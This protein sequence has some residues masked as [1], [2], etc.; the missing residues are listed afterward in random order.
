MINVVQWCANTNTNTNTKYNYTTHNNPMMIMICA[1][2][3]N[4]IISL[5]AIQLYRSIPSNDD[6]YICMFVQNAGTDLN[7][8]AMQCNAHCTSHNNVIKQFWIYAHQIKWDKLNSAYCD[9]SSLRHDSWCSTIYRYAATLSDFD[10]LCQYTKI[11]FLIDN[12]I[13]IDWCWL[14]FIDSDW[15]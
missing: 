7:C 11:F 10:H 8:C 2:Q 9:S 3:C 13:I 4:A 6:E 1:V 5:N 12:D 15:G 14:M